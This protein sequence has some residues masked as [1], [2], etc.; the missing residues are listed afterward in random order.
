[1]TGRRKAFLVFKPM[2]RVVLTSQLSP[3]DQEMKHLLTS[4][5]GSPSL[6][7][8]TLLPIEA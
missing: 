5:S 3:C 8:L 2:F 7:C 6:A 4:F 1:M